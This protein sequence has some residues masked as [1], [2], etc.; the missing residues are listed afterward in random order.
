MGL[1]KRV[2]PGAGHTPERNKPAGSSRSRLI[3]ACDA[4]RH[5]LM[6]WSWKGAESRCHEERVLQLPL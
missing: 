1:M 2:L 3:C 5:R 4:L 6:E